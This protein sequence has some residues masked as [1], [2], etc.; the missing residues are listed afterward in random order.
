[1]TLRIAGYEFEGPFFETH[2]LKNVPGVFAVISVLD[3]MPVLVDV[4]SSEDVHTSVE[5]H[6]RK[7]SWRDLAGDIAWAYA[8]IYAG[9]QSPDKRQSVV[10]KIRE[11][12]DVPCGD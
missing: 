10:R 3:N 2:Q 11:K 8:V 7:D 4:D 9:M 5:N 1:M 12:M 6:T